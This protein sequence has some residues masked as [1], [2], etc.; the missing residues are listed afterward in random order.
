[1][2]DLPY[3]PCVGIVLCNQDGLIFVAQRLD[4][5]EGAA[6][7]WQMP[8]GGIE[9]GETP[10]VAALR[11][12]AEETSVTQSDVVIIGQTRDWLCYDLPADL[13]PKL[14]NGRYRGQK[15]M[16][17]LMQFTGADSAINIQTDCPEFSNWQWM[18]AADVLTRI[19]PFKRAVYD[20]VFEDFGLL[21]L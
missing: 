14:W 12:L 3:R 20:Q 6:Q 21:K 19:V 15:Q 13:V 4:A 16:W 8:Q 7:A 1:M 5:G 9:D 10:R 18:A 17:Y 11:E 2:I